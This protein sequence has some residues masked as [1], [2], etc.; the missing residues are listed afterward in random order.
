MQI[1]L[2]GLRGGVGATTIGAVLAD[3]LSTAGESVLLIDTNPSDMLRLH[4]DVPYGDEQGWAN[5]RLTPFW[6]RQTHQINDTL[7]VL[8]YG[9]HRST[10]ICHKDVAA[11][12]DAFWAHY[13]TVLGSMYDWVLYDIPAGTGSYPLLRASSD[14]NIVVTHVDM[15]SHILLEQAAL[16]PAT[17]VLIN[18]MDSTHRLSND[19]LLAWRQR[20]GPHLVSD[21]VRGDQNIH[22]AFAHKMPV[23]RY[24]PSSSGARDMLAVARWCQAERTTVAA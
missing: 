19:I 6:R 13:R 10:Y 23:T 20:H 12:G 2:S 21:I 3:V 17:R 16:T 8:P 9:Y 4:F 24:S 22:E 1:T 18:C 7:A 11:D 15:A 14:L 5:A